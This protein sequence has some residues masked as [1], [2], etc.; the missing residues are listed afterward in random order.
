MQ[1]I[2]LFIVGATAHDWLK[3]SRLKAGCQ[4]VGASVWIKCEV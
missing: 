1:M 3:Q 2:S 4:L